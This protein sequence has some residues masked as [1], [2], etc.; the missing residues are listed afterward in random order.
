MKVLIVTS[1]R[2]YSPHTD[3]M[4]PFVYEQTN[5]LSHFGV[6]YKF[7]LV[8]H[9]IS[10]Y[11]KASTSIRKV[12]KDYAPEIVHAHYGLCGLVA[13]TQRKIPVITTFHGTDLN[14]PILRFFSLFAVLFSKA[15]IVVSEALKKTVCLPNRIYVIPCGINTDLLIPMDKEEARKRLMW[16]Y[17]KKYILFSKEFYNKAK[18]YPLAKASVD[19]YNANLSNGDCAELLE[20]IGYSREQVLLLYNAVDCVLMTSNNEGSPQ[21]IKEAMAC[22]CPIVSVDVGDVKQVISGTDGCY[23]AERDPSD[24]A[25][26]LD[27]AIK[28]G[29]TN[30]RNKVLKE[31]EAGVIA[32]K[33][34]RVYEEVIY[35]KTFT[36]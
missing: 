3:F 33:I 26:K 27:L 4:A 25:E 5:T 11:L 12:I 7:I 16:D 9:G 24:I 19:E 20:F 14:N 17:N 15:S 23:L 29:K 6:E 10:G 21:F 28:H 34:I 30:G 8:D 31:F 22:N 2:D 18:N 32:R 36:N 13:N 1:R 35:D